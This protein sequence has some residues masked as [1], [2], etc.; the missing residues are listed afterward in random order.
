MRKAELVPPARIGRENHE[1]GGANA[2]P[3]LNAECHGERV[4]T[5]EHY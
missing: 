4:H 2:A 1:R 5:K 3:N